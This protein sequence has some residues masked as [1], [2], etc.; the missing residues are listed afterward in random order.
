MEMWVG[1]DMLLPLDSVCLFCIYFYM[2][3]IEDV[4]NTYI[5]A[6]GLWRELRI[7]A[8]AEAVLNISLNYVLGRKYGLNGIIF[9]TIISLLIIN[10]L[11][12]SSVLFTRYFKMRHFRK[13]LL[14]HFFYALVTTIS[15]IVTYYICINLPVSWL[16]IIER[17]IICVLVPNVL[18]LGIYRKTRIYKISMR[19]FLS[20]INTPEDSL[21]G[22]LLLSQKDRSQN[23]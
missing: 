9:A 23:P 13:F 21:L 19:F 10:I 22:R 6:T 2:L 7:Y 15:C 1:K 8:I 11:L 4:R 14:D 17:G 5:Q 18:F 20:C 16:G 12:K 3:K